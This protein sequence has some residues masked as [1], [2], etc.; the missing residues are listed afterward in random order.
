[1]I[2]RNFISLQVYC[3]HGKVTAVWNFTPSEVMWTMIIKLP[4]IEVKFYLQ[5]KSNPFE[6]SLCNRVLLL[7]GK[8]LQ[9]NLHV[10]YHV[11]GT[12]F[13]GSL[14]SQTGLS[15]LR[16]SCKRALNEIY[17]V[18]K[19]VLYLNADAEAVKTEISMPRFPRGGVTC[20][21]VE[22]QPG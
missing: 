6:I 3:L 5:V 21:R 2:L 15:S 13:P 16:V 7:F 8:L 22:I 9:W 20:R 12:T 1:M 19:T 14:R 18:S 17:I 10:N 4:H 11:N